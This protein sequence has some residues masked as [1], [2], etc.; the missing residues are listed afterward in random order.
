M[1]EKMIT[2]WGKILHNNLDVPYEMRGANA[3]ALAPTS[4]VTYSCTIL[5]PIT[6][7]N[8]QWVEMVN[9]EG[10]NLFNIKFNKFY[11]GAPCIA[12]HD[13]MYYKFVAKNKVVKAAPNPLI[14]SSREG[15][16]IPNASNFINGHWVRAQFILTP[17][18]NSGGI[19]IS[20]KLLA[21]QYKEPGDPVMEVTGDV[22]PADGPPAGYYKA[23]EPAPMVGIQ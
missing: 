4:Q 23:S 9:N 8:T 1:A 12:R 18:T 13:N 17:Y 10:G 2:P 6:T 15:V 21:V 5:I 20:R 16:K 22:L 19:G 14:F 7:E 11:A 3:A